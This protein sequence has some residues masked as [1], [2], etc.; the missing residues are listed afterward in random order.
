[1]RS[2]TNQAD[3]LPGDPVRICVR[4]YSLASVPVIGA[5]AAANSW[6]KCWWWPTAVS[7]TIFGIA[8]AGRR[9]EPSN[10]CAR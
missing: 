3:A 6:P 7:A 1:L 10:P 9:V 4:W 5:H 2:L 8:T